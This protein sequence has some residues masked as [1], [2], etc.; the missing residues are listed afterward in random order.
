MCSLM[1]R[2]DSL[3]KLIFLLQLLLLLLMCSVLRFPFCN[4]N[5]VILGL[6]LL[7]NRKKC[8]KLWNIYLFSVLFCFLIKSFLNGD[9]ALCYSLCR[10]V[11]VQKGLSLRIQEKIKYYKSFWWKKW[12]FNKA[13]P[14]SVI[15]IGKTDYLFIAVITHCA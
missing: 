7:K 10:P 8:R 6:D 12:N 4:N 15:Q 9:I 5:L 3:I 2:P 14:R 1:Q 11:E 13:P